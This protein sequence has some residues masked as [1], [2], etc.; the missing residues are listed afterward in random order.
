MKYLDIAIEL[1]LSYAPKVFL[2]LVVLFVG[3]RLVRMAVNILNKALSH[4]KVDESLS[5]FLESLVGILLKGL[6]LITVANMVGIEMTSFI[7]LL[8]AAGLAIGL[9][10]QGSLS[11]FAG[12]ILILLFKPFKVG[13]LIETQGH[14]GRV[15]SIQIVNTILRTV[16]NKMV[17]IPNGA[18]SNGT[19]E[20]YSAQETRRLDMVFGIGYGDDIQKTKEVL[21]DIITT[22]DK[23]I[24]DEEPLI[25][26]SNLGASSVDIECRMWCANENYHPL[27]FEMNEMVKLRFDAEGISFPFPQQD[28]HVNMNPSALQQSSHTSLKT[29]FPQHSE[30]MMMPSSDLVGVEDE[31]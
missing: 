21:R 24:Q 16:D 18:I 8:G 25:V 15:D 6:V 13:D 29:S 30:K 20:N 1:F 31:G 17:V 23:V 2:A 4:E 14:R 19:V 28:I 27:R 10:L 11:N 7:A 26:V 5:S 12:G 9:S 3:F 22:H